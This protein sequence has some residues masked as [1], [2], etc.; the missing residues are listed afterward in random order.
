LIMIY[1]KPK[2]V[3]KNNFPRKN[4]FYLLVTAMKHYSEF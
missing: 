3:K 2:K 1:S 4:G